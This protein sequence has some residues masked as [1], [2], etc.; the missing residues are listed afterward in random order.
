MTERPF[1][2]NH[3]TGYVLSPGVDFDIVLSTVMATMAEEGTTLDVNSGLTNGDSFFG[4]QRYYTLTVEGKST[5]GV[6]VLTLPLGEIMVMISAVASHEDVTVAHRILRTAATLFDDVLEDEAPLVP[7]AEEV[8]WRRNRD[9]MSK[10]IDETESEINIPG[11]ACMYLLC[12]SWLRVRHSEVADENIADAAFEDFEALQKAA[13]TLDRFGF[14]VATDPEGKEHPVTFVSN[15]RAWGVQAGHPLL[16]LQGRAKSTEWNDLFRVTAG[17][18]AFRHFDPYNFEMSPMSRAEWE[19]LC[20][21]LPGEMYPTS[22]TYLLRWNPSI[23]S[24]TLDDYQ[25]LLAEGDS[26]E[27]NWSIREYED[28]HKGDQFFMLREGDGV[29]PGIMFR[30]VFTSDPY[31][32]EDWAG[33]D[34]KRYYADFECW[35]CADPDGVPCIT[36]DQ[37]QDALPDINWTKGHSGELL[38]PETAEILETIWEENISWVDEE[39]DESIAEEQDD[40]TDDMFIDLNEIDSDIDEEDEGFDLDDADYDEDD[41]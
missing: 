28:L 11:Y 17:N 32:G 4:R 1:D 40:G 38:S 35:A 2:I 13:S 31:E 24:F 27:G 30:G 16:L 33:T 36:L 15:R 5:T 10:L 8:L 29:N 34:K 19:T 18:P 39:Q 6:M 25:N 23:S 26:F 41:D 9:Y 12:P 21:F 14:T 20:E 7:G 22:K 3:P 37:L